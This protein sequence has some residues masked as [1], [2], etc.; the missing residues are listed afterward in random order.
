MVS[1]TEVATMT[2]PE[3]FRQWL[4]GVRENH[5]ELA[6]LLRSL[7]VDAEPGIDESLK[8]SSPSFVKDGGLRIYIADQRNYMHLGFYNGAKLTNADGLVEGTGK[9]MRHIKVRAIGNPPVDSLQVHVAES[10]A[11]EPYKVP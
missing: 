11:L 1:G 2:E 4:E 6:R 5:V 7:V 8:W 10:L 3:Y 9:N